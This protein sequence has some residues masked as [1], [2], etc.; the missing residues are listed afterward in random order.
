MGNCFAGGEVLRLVANKWH[1]AAQGDTVLHLQGKKAWSF[2]EL[3]S[4]TARP[5]RPCAPGVTRSVTVR[6]GWP[7]ASAVACEHARA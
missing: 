2:A 6:L 3:V 5:G 4:M 7:L 1:G